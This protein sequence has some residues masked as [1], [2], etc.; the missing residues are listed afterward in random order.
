MLHIRKHAPLPLA[1]LASLLLLAGC[2]GGGASSL[3]KADYPSG[4]VE[5]VAAGS[6]GGGLDTLARGLADALQREGIV[7]SPI[8]VV[9]KEGGS[10]GIGMTY[11]AGA[12]NKDH[13][14][15]IN[16]PGTLTTPLRGDVDVN[17]QD[18]T[19][20]PRLVLDEYV[21]LVDKDSAF[22]S[23]SELVEAAKERPGKLSI[24]GAQTG[25][26]D[27]ILST[28]LM[29]ATGTEF[30]YVPFDGGG[31]PIT[32]L[33]GGHVDVAVANTSEAGSAIKAGQVRPLAVASD[34]RLDG[35]SDV[36]TLRD[37][38]IELSVAFWRG[39]IAPQEMSDDA[40]SFWDK[41]IKE[42][43]GTR[44][45]QSFMEKNGLF[46]G[47]LSSED[48]V[49]FLEEQNEFYKTNLADLGMI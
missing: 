29:Q 34:D 40:A 45:W 19:I 36:P 44:S 14:L 18:F 16:A 2:G 9:N 24:G 33:M 47:Y 5:I 22:R 42:L 43:R 6:P 12:K 37:E 8:R 21:I 23:I 28:E 30:A 46:D 32:N 25:A 49:T 38:G 10:M 39:L 3:G 15:M 4:P 11:T 48:F 26:P 27:H 31:E 20:L 7:S 35:L 17:Y 41:A 13:T 1:A